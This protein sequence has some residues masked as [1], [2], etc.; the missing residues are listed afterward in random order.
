MHSYFIKSM[1]LFWVFAEMVILIFIRQGIAF[2]EGKEKKFL[3]LTILFSLIFILLFLTSFWGESF[4]SGYLDFSRKNH[5][6]FYRYAL[7]NLFCTLW[8]VLEGSIMF[9]SLHAYIILEK[10]MRPGR[11]PS[12]LFG[13]INPW[14]RYGVPLL[15]VSAAAFYLFYEYRIFSIMDRFGLEKSNLKNIY[16]FYIKICGLS[17]F[18]IEGAVALIGLKAYHLLKKSSP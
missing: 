14:T 3:G 18:L 12:E 8:V 4:F 6:F 13:T 15:V 1:G 16:L 17:W 2:V 7:W 11:M 9:Y 10:S 5:L